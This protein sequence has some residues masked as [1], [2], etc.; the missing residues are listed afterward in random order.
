M[1]C[2]GLFL[3]WVAVSDSFHKI[4]TN[5][6][7]QNALRSL[8]GA[9]YDSNLQKNVWDVIPSRRQSCARGLSQRSVSV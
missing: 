3:A 4:A 9:F 6:L 8:L 5:K 7:S 1:L 2:S